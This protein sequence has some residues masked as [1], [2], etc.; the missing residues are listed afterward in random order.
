MNEVLRVEDLRV[1]ID[2]KV[3]IKKAN[4]L[5]NDSDLVLIVGPN[6]SGKTSLI[7]AIA[8]NPKYKIL[9]GKIFFESEDISGLSMVERVEKGIVASFQ[10]PPKL[11]GI[12]LGKLA[13][14]ILKRK[15][16][17]D[18][19]DFI[20]KLASQLNLIEFLDRD[21]N[22][23]FSGGEMRRAELFLTLLHKP[24]LA[25]LDEIDS[26]VDIENIAL[27][28]KVL[29]R[30]ITQFK[31]NILVVT[32]TAS[33]ARYVKFNRTY[34]VVDGVVKE[35]GNPEEILRKI[36]EYGFYDFVGVVE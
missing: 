30:Y 11:K 3:V 2:G 12:T 18:P 13:Y 35:A 8:G 20:H 19:S 32:H 34:V 1:A 22:I 9:S 10:F 24:R 36:Q 17:D 5:V 27:I 23:G 15:G 14:E 21:L 4:L 16:Y 6:G 26:G 28:A 7:Q 31:I 33:I 29:N 25:L